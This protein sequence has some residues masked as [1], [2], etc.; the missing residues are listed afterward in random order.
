MAK[1]N[2]QSTISELILEAKKYYGLQKDYVR[3][4][5]AEQL[6]RVISTL[7]IVAVCFVVGLVIFVFAGLA[8][9]HFLGAAIGNIGLCYAIYAG[10]LLILLLLFYV[11][12]RRWVMRPLAR[13]F[14]NA[15]VKTDIKEE[16]D[17]DEED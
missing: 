14:I 5:A 17:D 9:V 7:A 3:Y 16:R 1:K 13:L 15:I 11:N 6:T 12:R 2:T 10:F 8:V 4:T